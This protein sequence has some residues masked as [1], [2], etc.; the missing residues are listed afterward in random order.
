MTTVL[1]NVPPPNV[2]PPKPSMAPIVKMREP[3][4][5]IT[6][7]PV[8]LSLLVILPV[9][10]AFSREFAIVFVPADSSIVKSWA[11]VSCALRFSVVALSPVSVTRPVPSAVP[12]PLTL[13]ETL[14]RVKPSAKVLF[15]LRPNEPFSPAAL[16]ARVRLPLLITWPKVI[17]PLDPSVILRVPAGRFRPLPLVENVMFA[18]LEAGLVSAI[19]IWK[20]PPTTMP[21]PDLAVAV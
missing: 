21:L 14:S 4:A 17:D 19:P 13:T 2:T 9:S 11:N 1:A 10:V 6:N 5:P 20:S 16:R 15:P 7:P 8:E 18:V 12:K 3:L